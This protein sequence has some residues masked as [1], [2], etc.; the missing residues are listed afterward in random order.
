V[1]EILFGTLGQSKECLPE[2]TEAYWEG[3]LGRGPPD[4][5][6]PGY[7]EQ[8][9]QLKESLIP[10]E[11]EEFEQA[12][13]VKSKGAPGPDG[14][15]WKRLKNYTKAEELAS[16]FN[17][18]LLCG[19]IPTMICEGRTTLVPKVVGTKDPSEYRPVTVCSVFT[20]LFHSILGN[21]LERLLPIS[22][23]QKGFRKG[24]GI[25]LNSDSPEMYCRSENEKEE[26]KSSIY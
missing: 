25:F 17:L 10:I 18:W 23:R 13:A 24:D 16:F 3:L 1:D 6:L 7:R 5:T 4:E 21:R 9:P 2:G 22:Q 26:P 15:T 20:R 12:L 14:Y 8:Q 11:T 19:R